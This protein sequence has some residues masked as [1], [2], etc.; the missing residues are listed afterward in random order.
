MYKRQWQQ[1]CENHLPKAP[2]FFHHDIASLTSAQQEVQMVKI[3][4]QQQSSLILESAPLLRIL[5]FKTSDEQGK[6]AIIAHH[7]LIDMVSSRLIF[8]DFLKSYEST[9]IGFKL[10]LPAKTSSI[11]Q[12]IF[13][14]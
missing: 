8:E 11:K 4:N 7:L 14:Q 5:H 13:F 9:R 1:T 12:L 3:I 2:Y 6:L 10:E